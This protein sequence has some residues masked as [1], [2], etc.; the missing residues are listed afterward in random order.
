MSGDIV[1]SLPVGIQSHRDAD[2]PYWPTE[3]CH[4]WKEVW[5]HPTGRWIWILSDLAGSP[6]VDAAIGTGQTQAVE[7]HNLATGKVIRISPDGGGRIHATVPEGEYEISAGHE[8]RRVALLP[9]GSYLL[10]LRP[11]HNLNMR[12]TQQTESNGAVTITANISGAGPHNLSL[13]ADNLTVDKPEQTVTIENGTPLTITWRGRMVAAD[14]PWTA[15]A[16]PDRDVEQRQELT[17]TAKS[18]Q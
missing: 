1:G 3:N 7:F 11:E 15:V 16:I 13:R 14:A 18:A 17:A 9:A 10:D 2:A 8:Q 12:L 5:V 6:I 4:N